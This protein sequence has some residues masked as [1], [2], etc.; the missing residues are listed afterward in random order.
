SPR[1]QAPAI[2]RGMVS[3][4][5]PALRATAPRGSRIFVGELAPVGTAT[6]VMGPLRFLRGWLC[7]N[8]RWK[9][10]RSG[11]CRHF[12]KVKADGVARSG[13]SALRWAGFQTGLRFANGKAK[14]SFAA[15]KLA[16]VVHKR[17]RGVSIWGHV[18]PGSGTRYVQLQRLQGG[19]FVNAGAPVRTNGGG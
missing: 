18:R 3:R 14:P 6:K 4:G 9:K 1:A 11:S 7:L 8:K 19:S 5:L 10:V 17:G 15:F 16:I 2:Y 13:S 12:K